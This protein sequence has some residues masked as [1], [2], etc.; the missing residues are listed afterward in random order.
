MPKA[1]KCEHIGECANLQAF[2]FEAVGREAEMKPYIVAGVAVILAGCV[3]AEE[4]AK[5]DHQKCA[6]FNIGST[7]YKTCRLLVLEAREIER[8]RAQ[9]FW[10]NHRPAR[11][12]QR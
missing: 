12:H 7:E 8:Q 6:T 3:A 5:R 1:T 2:G 4:L 11:A 10:R 9:K